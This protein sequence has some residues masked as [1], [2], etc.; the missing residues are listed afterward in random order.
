MKIISTLSTNINFNKPIINNI[1]AGGLS[2]ISPQ[3]TN[4]L[5]TNTKTI[6][7][8]NINSGSLID[9]IKQVYQNIQNYFNDNRSSLGLGLAVAGLLG[10]VAGVLLGGSLGLIIKILDVFATVFTAID[11]TFFVPS[12]MI[13]SFHELNQ[14]TKDFSFKTALNMLLKLLPLF[15]VGKWVFG[16]KFSKTPNEFG[17]LQ[18]VKESKI[19]LIALAHIPRAH[20]KNL[21][22]G[23]TFLLSWYGRTE[24]CKYISG[25]L[26]SKF[27]PLKTANNP[28]FGR[29]QQSLLFFMLAVFPGWRPKDGEDDF[30]IK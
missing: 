23:I 5:K 6:N 14:M 25:H 19:P 12:E 21:S 22:G 16:H 28:L 29:F 26:I 13:E 11:Y 30:M 17:N 15:F 2:S 27:L 7:S 4:S 20:I 18:K 10:S 3:T 1:A 9:G 8:N 24:L